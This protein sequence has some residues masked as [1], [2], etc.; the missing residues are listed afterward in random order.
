MVVGVE[1]LSAVSEKLSSH[2]PQEDGKPG[3]TRT[4]SDD[5]DDFH[6]PPSGSEGEQEGGG[7]GE[8]LDEAAERKTHHD[9]DARESPS[10]LRRTASAGALDGKSVLAGIAGLSKCFISSTTASYNSLANLSPRLS[11]LYTG[12]NGSPVGT[13]G[14]SNRLLSKHKLELKSPRK[15]PVKKKLYE[16]PDLDKAL[17]HMDSFRPHMH[18]GE[19]VNTGEDSGAQSLGSSGGLSESSVGKGGTCSLRLGRVSRTA[20]LSRSRTVLSSRRAVELS[21]CTSSPLRLAL[22]LGRFS[23]MISF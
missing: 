20:V 9:D 19:S 5:F 12:N 18:G 4:H 11:L 15:T 10:G 14:R 16:P 17:A 6:T 8:G 7:E 2:E 23:S 21:P 3:L 13:I 1:L 22:P